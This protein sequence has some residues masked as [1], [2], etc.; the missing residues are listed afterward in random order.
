MRSEICRYVAYRPIPISPRR[1]ATSQINGEWPSPYIGKGM[2]FRSHRAYQL[3]DDLRSVNM[4]MSIRAGKRMVVERV[5][6]RDISIYILLD[7]S[8][9]MGIRT[10][11]QI[12]KAV[13][14]MILYS[15]SKMEMRVG[16]SI[17][18][19]KGYHN[20]GL[21]MGNRHSLRLMDNIEN[22]CDDLSENQL[23]EVDFESHNLQKMLPTGC[24]LFYI[25]DYLDT[26]GNPSP[27]F[28]F[29]FNSKKYD[30]I[31]VIIQDEFEYSFP[32]LP[33]ETLIELTDPESGELYPFW[34]DSGEVQKIKQINKSRFSQI[35]E[36]LHDRGLS[37]IH[38]S[39]SDI[40][41]LHQ[42]ISNYFL[43]R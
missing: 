36:G 1:L 37:Y 40:D 3:G 18:T 30:L 21:G 8:A 2:D 11:A 22:I 15:G 20:L 38:A 32:E 26:E 25:S 39:K 13:A 12:M 34:F 9:S 10:K 14:L 16:A 19:D 28:P 41:Y 31:P 23:P 43:Y 6:M 35:H 4:A 27:D 33:G 17:L 24:I 7:C 29:V 42:S 5:A